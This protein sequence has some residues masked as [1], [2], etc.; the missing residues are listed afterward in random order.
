[1]SDTITIPRMEIE[2]APG[3]TLFFGKQGTLWRVLEVDRENDTAQL[4][5]ERQI[6]DRQ[7]H[8]KAERVDWEHCDLRAW[9]NGEYFDTSFSDEEKAGIAETHLANPDNPQYNTPGGNDTDDRIFLLSIDEAEKYFKDDTDRATGSWWWWLRSPGL[10]SL[11]AA[12]VYDV[13]VISHFGYIVYYNV[14][15]RPAFKI[16]LKSDIF[17]SIILSESDESI[18]V[19]IPQFAV[20]GGVLTESQKSIICADIP[21]GVTSIREGAF[22]RRT[23]L[24]SVVLPSTLKVIGEEAFLGCSALKE[25][26]IPYGVTEIGKNAFAGCKN[27]NCITAPDILGAEMLYSAGLIKAINEVGVAELITLAKKWDK[28]DRE[29]F[30]QEYM[31]SDTRAAMLLAEKRKELNKYAAMRGMDTDELRDK[32]LSDLGLDM[33]GRKS[34]DGPGE[35]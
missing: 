23:A 33:H 12:G 20:N 9:L 34:Y 10:L 32:Y 6:C 25:V 8:S 11:S 13:G 24:V 31:R 27:L 29:R 28:Y 30:Y 4:I 26:T 15:V 18:I 2:F 5:A 7:Y 21:E 35:I 19:S 16:N 14:C 3:A 17:Q 1:M 22:A